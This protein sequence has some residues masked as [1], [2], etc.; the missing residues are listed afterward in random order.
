MMLRMFLK[1]AAQDV[2]E[3]VL[4][5]GAVFEAAAQEFLETVQD[6]AWDVLEGSGQ[7]V[8]DDVSWDFLEAQDVL[9]AAAQDVLEADPLDQVLRKG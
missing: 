5:A 4:E 9:E 8:L 2:L 3:A 6:A 7:D 1:A